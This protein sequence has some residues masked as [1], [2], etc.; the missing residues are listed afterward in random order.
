MDDSENLVDIFAL[1]MKELNK[2]YILII[3]HGSGKA[4]NEEDIFEIRSF[5]TLTTKE[6]KSLGLTAARIMYK[7]NDGDDK[8]RK[9]MPDEDI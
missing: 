3:D 2:K 4:D 6:F 8:P 5:R 7:D 1:S 9:L